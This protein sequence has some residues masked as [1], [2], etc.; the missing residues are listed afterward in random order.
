MQKTLTLT[1]QIIFF[2]VLTMRKISSFF[3][4]PSNINNFS[5]HTIIFLSSSLIYYF[6]CCCFLSLWQ[7]KKL[8]LK[9]IQRLR[10]RGKEIRFHCFSLLMF[11]WNIISRFL[12]MKNCIQENRKLHLMAFFSLFSLKDNDSTKSVIG[13]IICI[14]L[15]NDLLASNMQQKSIIIFIRI[16]FFCIDMNVLKFCKKKLLTYFET[17]E[18]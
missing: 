9:R 12:G 11:D 18:N 10:E 7:N 13:L 3:P 2:I 1:F 16:M 8:I 6:C 5:L 15:T 4:M 14:T 17:P